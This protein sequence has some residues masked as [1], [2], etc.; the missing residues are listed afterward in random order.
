MENSLTSVGYVALGGSIGSTIRF[1]ITKTIDAHL[2]LTVSA[3]TILINVFGSFL[4]GVLVGYWGGSVQQIPSETRLLLLTGL[5]G[6]FTTFSAFSI[7]CVA[8]SRS[9]SLFFSLFYVLMHVIGSVV[10]AF[11]GMYLSNRLLN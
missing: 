1:L 5:L 6:G 4:A 7:E 9:E 8:I 10:A 2:P 11:F 3:G